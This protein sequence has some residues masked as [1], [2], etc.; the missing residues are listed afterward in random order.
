MKEISDLPIPASSM[1][2][3]LWPVV[4]G[5]RAAMMLALLFQLEQS[6]WWAP[7]RLQAAQFRQAAE[8]LRRA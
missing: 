2:G 5:Q 4:P 6:Q 1:A 3:N 8:V 7:E